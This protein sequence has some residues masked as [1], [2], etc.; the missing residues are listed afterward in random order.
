MT[1]GVQR[2]DLLG[3]YR[4]Y[5]E[6]ADKIIDRRGRDNIFY[7]TLVSG[8]LAALS[9]LL[10]AGV[11]ESVAPVIIGLSGAVAIALC[12]IWFVNIRVY[13]R[14]SWAKFKVIHQMEEQLPFPCFKREWALLTDGSSDD[15]YWGLTRNAGLVPI[16]VS[17]AF[18][19]LFI[20]SLLL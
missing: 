2:S 14:L 3:Q 13:R 5:V 16:T 8:L 4:I 9:T 17:L 12:G 19:G 15:G 6:T 20:A 11:L 10:S 7:G 18:V 1:T